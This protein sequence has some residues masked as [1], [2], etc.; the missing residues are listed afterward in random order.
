MVIILS[1]AMVPAFATAAASAPR[2]HQQGSS[3]S[4]KEAM[5]RTIILGFFAALNRGNL[6]HLDKIVRPD[7]IQHYPKIA[8][9]RAAFRQYH[10]GL[11]DRNPDLRFSVKRTVAQGDLVVAHS[12]FV[13]K[14][15]DPGISKVNVFRLSDGKIAEHWEANEAVR[16]PGIGND[17]FSTLSSPRISRPLPLATDAESER[18]GRAAFAEIINQPNDEIRRQ[19]LDRLIGDN[20]YYQHY[21]NVPNGK[22]AL[23]QFIHDAFAV[24]PEYRANVK[25]VVAE[26]DLVALIVHIEK[27]FDIE[28]SVSFDLL[29]VRDGK[30]V[31]H[32]ATG[33]EIPA[34]SAN[35]H[36][37][38]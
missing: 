20:T 22:A 15:G 35:P 6:G 13:S 38:Y 30:L 14:A 9:G 7:L 11:R 24:Q 18:A 32:W 29:R 34:T 5:N 4:F 37:M 25:I 33:E 3:T 8:D 1:I 12:H 19:A 36:T 28:N 21:P 16:P 2:Q 26:H 17:M 23:D 31:E 10:A 27:L